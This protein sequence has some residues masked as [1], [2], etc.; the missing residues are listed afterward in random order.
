M[1][2]N[3]QRILVGEKGFTLIE[4][5]IVIAIIGILAAVAI[6]NFIS[7]RDKAFCSAA[8]N[9]ARSI[10]ATLADYFAVPSRTSLC[11]PLR[12]SWYWIPSKTRSTLLCSW[13]VGITSDQSQF[14]PFIWKEHCGR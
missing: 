10:A 3:K 1:T 2:N 9:D 6:P 8:E 14:F 11:V 12:C 5:M 7:Y 4:L 13:W